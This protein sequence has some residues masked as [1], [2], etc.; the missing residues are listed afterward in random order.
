[1]NEVLIIK[2]FVGGFNDK[3]IGHEVINF[4][5]P[6]NCDDSYIY[7]PPIGQV[8]KDKY[9]KIE[10]IIMVGPPE[11]YAYPILAIANKIMGFNSDEERETVEKNTSYGGKCI[12]EIAF[13]QDHSDGASH[14]LN[15]IVPKGALK[16]PEKKIYIIPK[17]HKKF[18]KKIDERVEKIK[19]L[20]GQY[21][22]LDKENP[23][24]SVAYCS[25]D[26]SNKE[27]KKLLAEVENW[28]EYPLKEIDVK[29]TVAGYIPNSILAFIDKEYEEQIY[30]NMLYSII[31]NG[32]TA[33]ER[34]DFSNFMLSKIATQ[35][36][37]SP[38]ENCKD[39]KVYKEK[40]ALTDSQSLIVTVF[41]N[42][43]EE[44]KE[45]AEKKLKE[46]YGLKSTKEMYDSIQKQ[47]GRI[48][49]LLENEDYLIIIENKVRSALNGLYED[50]DE[51]KTQLNKYENFA[52]YYK[53]ENKT[54][55]NAKSHIIVFTPNYN[56]NIELYG[57]EGQIT[58]ITYSDL[59]HYFQNNYIHHQ[60][61]Y[62]FY[63]ALKLHACN[64]EEQINR[65]FIN[66]LTKD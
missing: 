50:G 4:Y 41:G 12:K 2:M 34:I 48:D 23:Q 49:L 6:D 57:K 66:V 65:R 51:I 14:H 35:L 40:H 38:M 64:R 54:I 46:N 22:I 44:T 32:M 18:D 17:V 5:K 58:I 9:K 47:R 53:K 25:I 55:E 45:K 16:K 3:N 11:N 39:L 7:V 28:V 1:M 59:E 56:V 24:H 15:F 13:A 19:K 10:K 37:T 43:K 31:K 29:K 33:Q 60:Y 20:G 30:T 63:N 26:D 62:E 52:K 42:A 61:F 21:I 27:L 8:A 36:E